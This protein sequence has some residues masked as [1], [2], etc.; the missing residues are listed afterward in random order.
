MKRIILALNMLKHFLPQCCFLIA[1]IVFTLILITGL[2]NT[3]NWEMKEYNAFQIS[4]FDNAIYFSGKFDT[5]SLKLSEGQGRELFEY[6]K[7]QPEFL[8]ISDIDQFSLSIKTP[9]GTEDYYSIFT[10]DKY[11]CKILGIDEN[12]LFDKEKIKQGV[13][14]A[15]VYSKDGDVFALGEKYAGKIYDV[16][17]YSGETKDLDKNIE[18]EILDIRKSTMQF[19]LTYNA[20]TNL[21]IIYRL[22][23]DYVKTGTCNIFVPKVEELFSGYEEAPFWILLNQNTTTDRMDEILAHVN[24]YGYVFTKQQTDKTSL[25]GVDYR[26]GRNTMNSIMLIV[27]SIIGLF[28]LSFL[29]VKQLSKRLSI[30]YLCG[31]GKL[32]SIGLYALFMY[33]IGAGSV[34]VYYAITTFQ[35]YFPL[36]YVMEL[37]FYKY[38]SFN[39][40]GLISIF[41]CFALITLFSLVPFAVNYKKS[42]L[43]MYRL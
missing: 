32:K 5:E 26:L 4:E 9:D 40:A 17:Y 21:E 11:T 20:K 1:E 7:A 6:L 23:T 19:Y 22:F 14:P 16:V 18:L 3:Y 10:A 41:I 12:A 15:V 13:L 39:A 35:Y 38:E 25:K 43:E 30:Y 2:I 8:G 42:S 37:D 27:L 24:K 31:C 34:L 29:S 33:I 36:N 28:T